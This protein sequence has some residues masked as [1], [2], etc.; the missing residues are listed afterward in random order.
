MSSFNPNRLRELRI[1]R[2]LTLDQLAGDLGVTKQAVS[3]YEHGKST[4]SYETFAKML[5]ILNVPR[6][7]LVKEDVLLD[8]QSFV[9]FFRAMSSTTRSNV[10]YADIV[11]RWGYDILCG[12]KIQKENKANFPVFDQNL[13]IPEKALRLRYLWNIGTLPVKNMTALLER[14]GISVFVI[15]SEELHT[16]AYSRTINGIPIVVLN[17]SK[18]TAVRWRFSLAHE[19]GHLI[20]H[21]ELSETEF[22][23]RS[24][25]IED[26][27]N[28][29]ASHFLMPA[30]EF[31]SSVI[32][33]KLENFLALKKE[34]GV[35]IAAMIYHCKQLGIIDQRRA[36]SL[37]KQLSKKGW[38][39]K[40][41]FDDAD[42]FEAPVGLANRV[43]QQITDNNSFDLFY[44]LVRLPIDEI[45]RLCS[46]P[47][48][49]FSAY[50]SSS[51]PEEAGASGPDQAVF[52]QLSLFQDGGISHA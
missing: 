30:E 10:E 29:F 21:R 40:E 37:Q 14:Q 41:P 51:M 35:S 47:E 38:R 28:L 27:A 20:L 52:E 11:S 5:T 31:R 23:L 26:E 6:K 43:K 8:Q 18:G 15:N 7:Y 1:V 50:R 33:P 32:I 25:E 22:E 16:D 2:K 3:K 49:Y 44:D 24:K 42:Q 17:G 13:T 39:K 48:G 36:D 45:E 19:L 12:L 46:L 9:I 34:W 4:P